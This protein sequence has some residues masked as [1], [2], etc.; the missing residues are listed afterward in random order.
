MQTF[1]YQTFNDK[2]VQLHQSLPSLFPLNAYNTSGCGKGSHKNY[3]THNNGPN[4]DRRQYQSGC[5]RPMLF[6]VTAGQ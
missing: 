4:F 2:S 5:P 3:A 1:L 6:D